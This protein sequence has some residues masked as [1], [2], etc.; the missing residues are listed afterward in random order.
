MPPTE[1]PKPTRMVAFF[2]MSTKRGVSYQGRNKEQGK[3]HLKQEQIREGWEWFTVTSCMICR[4]TAHQILGR[5]LKE[6]GMGI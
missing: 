1:V 6:N 5:Q 3:F 2:G 4:P